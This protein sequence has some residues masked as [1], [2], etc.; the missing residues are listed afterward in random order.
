MER[1]DS[2]LP[3]LNCLKSRAFLCAPVSSVI[4]PKLS[5]VGQTG[6]FS[7]SMSSVRWTFF[8]VSVRPVKKTMA[9]GTL[10]LAVFQRRAEP[11]EGLFNILLDSNERK[12]M[13]KTREIYDFLKMV[14]NILV[15]GRVEGFIQKLTPRGL[16]K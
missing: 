13:A 14:L 1:E 6:T 9:C 7:F 12:R 16:Q 8:P 11:M 15:D 5:A 4:L 10:S 3:N 2:W